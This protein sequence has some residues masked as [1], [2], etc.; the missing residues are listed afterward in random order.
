MQN[1]R[2]QWLISKNHTN[3]EHLY[4]IVRRGL[5][6]KNLPTPESQLQ[7]LKNSFSPVTNQ[8][9]IGLGGRKRYDTLR[10]LLIIA[11]Y[12]NSSTEE[13]KSVVYDCLRLL[14]GELK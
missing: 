6:L 10:N 8:R 3:L 5:A 2:K 4:Y 9:K 13:D 14:D 7:R 12:S 1:L 11:Q